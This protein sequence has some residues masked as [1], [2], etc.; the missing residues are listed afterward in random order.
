[1]RFAYADPPYLGR[2]EYYIAHHPDAMQ[3]N[4]PETHRALI[5]RL[6][7]EYKDGWVLSLSEKSLRTILPM[8]PAG[9][10]IGA[11]ITDRPRFAGKPVTV[12][13]H[14]EPVIFFGGRPHKEAGN[15]TADFIITKQEPMANGEKRYVM[16]KSD[17]RA[18]KTFVGRKPEAFTLWV[19]DLLGALQGDIIDDLFPGSGAV[20]RALKAWE[21]GENTCGQQSMFMTNQIEGEAS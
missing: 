8:C 18:G 7:D 20:T 16:R 4:N 2:G 10:R 21:Q 1:M 11:W 13:K 17:I 6:Q 3:W 5:E 19:T 12:R 15:R 9:S 14:F